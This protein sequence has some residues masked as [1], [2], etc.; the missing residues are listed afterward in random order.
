M[1][2]YMIET[3]E[4]DTILHKQRQIYENLQYLSEKDRKEFESKF[5]IP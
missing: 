3:N 5:T 2:E 1:R 4:K